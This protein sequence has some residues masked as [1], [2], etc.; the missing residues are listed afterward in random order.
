M[1]VKVIHPKS[2]GHWLD[3]VRPEGR[4]Q[5]FSTAANAV[6]ILVRT[7]LSRLARLRHSS[8]DRLGARRTGHVEKGARATHFTASPDGA[9]VI[10]PIAGMSRA[11][12]D[13]TVTPRVASAL[14]LPVSARAYGKRV[15]EMR[16]LG[17]RVFRPKGKDV[18]MD[19]LKDGDE[20][21]PLYALKRRVTQ[22]QDRTLLPS[23]AELSDAAGVAAA[24]YIAHI[25][26]RGA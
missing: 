15:G 22:R 24:K 5:I 8:A 26:G 25:A 21:V 16:R 2:L 14:T 3:L 10:I 9:T 19:Y 13:V 23:D 20:P 12:R 17:W 18:L 4:R 1:T 11:L 7:H 6:R